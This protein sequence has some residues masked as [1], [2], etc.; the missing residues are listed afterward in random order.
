LFGHTRSAELAAVNFS[1]IVPAGVNEV[2]KPAQQTAHAR[3]TIAARNRYL[4]MLFMVYVY[5]HFILL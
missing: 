3:C 4:S 5:V 1:N 2:K